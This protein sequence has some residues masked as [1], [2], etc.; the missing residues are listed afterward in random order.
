MRERLE[1][2][3]HT[4]PAHLT[5]HSAPQQGTKVTLEVEIPPAPAQPHQTDHS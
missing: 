3:R 1:L 4:L 2:I 5:V